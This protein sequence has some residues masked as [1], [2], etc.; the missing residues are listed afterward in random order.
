M[1]RL[2]R[3]ILPT[4]LLWLNGAT[5]AEIDADVVL[6]GGLIVDG[7]AALG[8]KGDLAIRG[9][10][11]VAIGTFDPPARATVI[12]VSGKV[13]APGFID[14]HSHSDSSI[15]EPRILERISTTSRKA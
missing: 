13:V 12:D 7:T 3:W 8:R 14:L 10:R 1:Q 5:G 6:R 11:I 15:L 2:L 9:D 4:L